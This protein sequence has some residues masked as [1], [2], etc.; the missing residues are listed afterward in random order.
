M[1]DAEA[2]PN[3]SANID[4]WI[5]CGCHGKVQLSQASERFVI[6]ATPTVIPPCEA[7]IIL[8]IDGFLYERPVQLVDGF[9]ASSREAAVLSPENVPA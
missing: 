2:R 3:H 5:D 6:A 9:S 4:L 1:S 8:S 7:R